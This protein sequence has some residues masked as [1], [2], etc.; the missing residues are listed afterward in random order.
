MAVCVLWSLASSFLLH[1][2]GFG[3]NCVVCSCHQFYFLYGRQDL[4][5]PF[6]H[7]CSS[8]KKTDYKMGRAEAN[9]PPQQG[10][11][12]I[13]DIFFFHEHPRKINMWSGAIIVSPYIGPL[14]TAFIINKKPWP[15]A[16]WVT[17]GIAALCWLLVIGL[18]DETIYNRR[19]QSAQQLPPK[20][21]LLRL[22]GVEQWR[23]R[24]HRQSL[25][26]AVMRPIIAFSKVP[27]ILCTV[28]YFLNFA[29]AIGVN[30]TTSI[31][32]TSIYKFTPY[33]LG[34]FHNV[35]ANH[36]SIM[37]QMEMV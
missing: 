37:S 13:Q 34:K 18:A 33:N 19:L 10:L 4:K 2:N 30:A 25:A 7:C 17:T 22:I 36:F 21:R 29:W 5:W 27:V 9:D 26:Q 20:S 3:N 1:V 35:D 32:L 14:I 8:G 11:M 16:Y 24:R 31:W 23:S 28:F 12:M 6:L 15:D